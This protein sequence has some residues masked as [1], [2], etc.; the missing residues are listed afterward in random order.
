LVLNDRISKEEYQ[1][2]ESLNIL[3]QRK[4]C[5]D[6]QKLYDINKILEKAKYENNKIK[7]P[8]SATSKKRKNLLSTLESTELSLEEINEAKNA[9]YLLGGK[10]NKVSEYSLPMNGGE[11]TIAVIRKKNE[12]A[13][14]YPRNSGKIKAKP[15]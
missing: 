10:I 12:T 9:I 1:I 8:I 14:K 13:K 5:I 11:R 3:E 15:L 6:E 4:R 2:K 7:E